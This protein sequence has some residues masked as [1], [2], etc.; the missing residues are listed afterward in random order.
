M[1]RVHQALKRA[2]AERSEGGLERGAPVQDGAVSVAE[3][4]T[5]GLPSECVFSVVPAGATRLTPPCLPTSSMPAFLPAATGRSFQ[6]IVRDMAREERDLN[7]SE[8]SKR[9][10]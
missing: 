1:S 8:E 5:A 10:R 7:V 3:D 4:I 6:D 9:S 2:R